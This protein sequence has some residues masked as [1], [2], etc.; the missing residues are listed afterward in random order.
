MIVFCTVAVLSW[1]AQ[2][3]FTFANWA[4]YDHYDGSN[5]LAD[6]IPSGNFACLAHDDY[7]HQM[8]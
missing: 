1:P 7:S 4:Q 6:L 8:L 5:I 3:T 2:T